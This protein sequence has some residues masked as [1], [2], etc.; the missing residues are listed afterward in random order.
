L[1]EIDTNH[2]KERGMNQIIDPI[3]AEGAGLAARTQEALLIGL[4]RSGDPNVGTPVGPTEYRSL[5]K[6]GIGD[7]EQFAKSNE[8]VPLSAFM[9]WENTIAAA[10][11]VV[12]GVGEIGLD[13]TGA[14][15][16]LRVTPED[17]SAPLTLPIFGVPVI[18]MK[19]P[20][21][22]S[23][24]NWHQR[25]RATSADLPRALYPLLNI[26]RAA[27]LPLTARP[28]VDHNTHYCGFSLLLANR[29]RIDITAAAGFLYPQ[30]L[31]PT[32]NG[33][34]IHDHALRQLDQ[35]EPSDIIDN[36]DCRYLAS[37]LMACR[38][39]RLRRA[40]REAGK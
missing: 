13:Q 14:Q 29:H 36:F 38:Y 22:I 2:Q 33:A 27:N 7:P 21:Q 8:R 5:K 24:P 9:Y 23:D 11:S 16:L 40:E 31:D 37:A 39:G 15:L 34:S 32:G 28:L 25:P 19:S 3:L 20:L 26:G 10:G 35:D 17:N 18:A 30:D 4:P 12:N 1:R 6:A